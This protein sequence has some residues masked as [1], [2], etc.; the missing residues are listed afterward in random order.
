[1]IHACCAGETGPCLLRGRKSG[2]SGAKKISLKRINSAGQNSPAP[3]EKKTIRMRDIAAKLGVS[4]VTVSNALRGKPGVSPEVAAKVRELAVEQGYDLGRIRRGQR[5]ETG[6]RILV[7]SPMPSDDGTDRLWSMPEAAVRTITGV[8]ESNGFTVI[9]FTSLDEVREMPL[10]VLLLYPAERGGRGKL[11]RMGI[12]WIGIGWYDAGRDGCYLSDDVFH[13][14]ARMT[15]LLLRKGAQSVACGIPS[16]DRNPLEPRCRIRDTRLGYERTLWHHLLPG[17]TALINDQNQIQAFQ[18]TP[19]PNITA[20]PGLLPEA[21]QGWILGHD[22]YLQDAR[23]HSLESL[24][25]E[26]SLVLEDA[27]GGERIYLKKAFRLHFPDQQIAD[28]TLE[29]LKELKST[30][31][32]PKAVEL[33]QGVI[34]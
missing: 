22:A 4:T 9:P 11:D 8:L 33:F 31:R 14:S 26:S 27:A 12:P 34:E 7:W 28:R 13:E 17:Q 18:K 21:V 25:P 6:S 20:K 19:F 5:H 32:L 24:Q 29:L 3:K 10:G 16:G 2:D 23:M 15:E 1:M 30:G